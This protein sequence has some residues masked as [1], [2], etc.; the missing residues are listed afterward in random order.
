MEKNYKNKAYLE[1]FMVSES[2]TIEITDSGSK[3]LGYLFIG[4]LIFALII[5]NVGFG[6]ISSIMPNFQDKL[7]VILLLNLPFSAIL[8]YLLIYVYGLFIKISKII[9]SDKTIEFLQFP[10]R[11]PVIINWSDFDT[12]RLKVK[13][14]KSHKILDAMTKMVVIG[15]SGQS[16]TTKLLIKFLRNPPNRF[17]KVRNLKLFDDAKV[18]QIIDSLISIAEKLDK[19]IDIERLTKKYYRPTDRTFSTV[20]DL[21]SMRLPIAPIFTKKSSE[22]ANS[23]LFVVAKS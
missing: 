19:N 17:I 7:G 10:K 9:I 5:T 6:F 3:Y 4:L 21:K 1:N 12:I 2:N 16:M 20:K 23:V 15:G 14:L 22:I 13:G 18:S 8:L 11:H